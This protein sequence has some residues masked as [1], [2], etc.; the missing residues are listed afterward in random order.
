MVASGNSTILNDPWANP[1]T[2]AGTKAPPEAPPYDENSYDTEDKED[3]TSTQ[4]RE[5]PS[6]F[7]REP[8]VRDPS[9][10][11]HADNLWAKTMHKSPRTS[12][13]DVATKHASTKVAGQTSSRTL[14]P[15]EASAEADE[16]ADIERTERALLAELQRVAERRRS[17]RVSL[18]TSTCQPIEEALEDEEPEATVEE[19]L[20]RGKRRERL[21]AERALAEQEALEH[22]AAQRRAVE[23]EAKEKLMARELEVM[24]VSLAS[25]HHKETM[26]QYSSPSSRR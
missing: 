3:G 21:A 5:S 13:V 24:R 1:R 14:T 16:S 20:Q 26:K 19:I 8:Q 12:E 17:M 9:A 11:Q 6:E 10:G 15:E 22:A 25:M 2:G 18:S 4:W 7:R 23:A